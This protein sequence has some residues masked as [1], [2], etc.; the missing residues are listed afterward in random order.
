MNKEQLTA[1][2]ELK[3]FDFRKNGSPWSGHWQ[4]LVLQWS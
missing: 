3:S 1:S 2:M 4:E